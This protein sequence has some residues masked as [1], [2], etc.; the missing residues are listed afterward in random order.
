MS[1]E[2]SSSGVEPGTSLQT[3]ADKL[4]TMKFRHRLWGVSE[5]DVWV[6]VKRIDEMYRS[7]YQ[8]QEAKYQ[9]LLA[10]RDAT[11]AR[12]QRDLLRA[13]KSPRF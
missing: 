7:L 10:D 2:A 6:K 3:I 13:R 5:Q 12:L 9:A 1:Q 8:E 11:I 4:Q